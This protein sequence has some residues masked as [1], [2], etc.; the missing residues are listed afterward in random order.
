MGIFRRSIMAA[1]A[2][3][4]FGPSVGKSIPPEVVKFPKENHQV[5]SGN[6]RGK[7]G[8]RF[9]TKTGNA[10]VLKRESIK[11]NNKRKHRRGSK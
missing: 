10:A 4:G 2:M 3:L 6:D 8:R 11:R 9:T 7:G 5:R 1:I